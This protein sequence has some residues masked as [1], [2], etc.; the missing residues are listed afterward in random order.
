MSK[1]FFLLQYDIS[2]L[3]SD[4]FISHPDR[5]NVYV[6]LFQLLRKKSSLL[7][8]FLMCPILLTKPAMF[9][10]LTMLELN[11]THTRTLYFQK[12]CIKMKIDLKN[13]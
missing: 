11:Q 6:I 13:D 1:K 10:L 2:V 5:K 8:F 3:D 9:N 7:F 12:F 4:C